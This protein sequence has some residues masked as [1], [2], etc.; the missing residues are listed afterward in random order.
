M[1]TLPFPKLKLCEGVR[2][3]CEPTLFLFFLLGREGLL[4]M[5]E[6]CYK[7]EGVRVNGRE[8][9]RRGKGGLK[10]GMGLTGF[11]PPETHRKPST[12][13]RPPFP[14]TADRTPFSRTADRPPF[15]K[16]AD[17]DEPRH[18]QDMHKAWKKHQNT[19]FWVN[20]NRVFLWNRSVG[21]RK[22][23]ILRNTRSYPEKQR[24]YPEK[25][26]FTE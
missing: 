9:G 11:T 1:V 10:K 14:R 22:G 3:I 20:M 15:P 17:L 5:G 4:K 18:A 21:F 24:S 25:H 8:E 2:P 13:D 7:R 16:T 12:A 6:K 23:P 26:C 19:V